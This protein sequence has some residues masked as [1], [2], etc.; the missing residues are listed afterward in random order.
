MLLI[1]RLVIMVHTYL[2][3]EIED[4]KVPQYGICPVHFG[5]A[6]LHVLVISTL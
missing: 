1:N 2:K 5:I 4:T 3:K 6:P